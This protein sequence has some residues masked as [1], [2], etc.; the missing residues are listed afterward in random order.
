MRYRYRFNNLLLSCI[1]LFSTFKTWTTLFF[2]LPL[3]SLI[4]SFSW[5]C[6]TLWIDGLLKFH[7]LSMPGCRLVERPPNLN[8]RRSDW[9]WVVES[10]QIWFYR[11]SSKI[12]V[13]ELPPSFCYLCSTVRGRQKHARIYRRR[14]TSTCIHREVDRGLPAD[15]Q[16]H[17]QSPSWAYM[18]W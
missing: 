6:W 18:A 16:V 14:L 7:V 4:R 11:G 5:F 12:W 15:L 1:H 13:I 9:Q 3:A 8:W 2:S 10:S 17:H